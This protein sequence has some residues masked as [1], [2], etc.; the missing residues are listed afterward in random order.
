MVLMRGVVCIAQ[1]PVKK[2][3]THAIYNVWK[4]LEKQLNPD[5]SK[6]VSYEINPL[7]GDSWLHLHKLVLG[8]TDSIFRGQNAVFA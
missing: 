8:N 4:K 7:M 6:I 2:P 3:H 5:N 1:T